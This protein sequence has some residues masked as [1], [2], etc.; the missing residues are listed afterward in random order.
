MTYP[1]AE[2]KVACAATS[3]GARGPPEPSAT[4]V[5]SQAGTRE[6]C[7]ITGSPR[8]DRRQQSFEFEDQGRT[9][10]CS[11]EPSHPSRSDSWWYFGVTGDRT[12]YAV[13]Q[14]SSEDTR[15]SVQRRI[16]AHYSALL[17]R[18]AQIVPYRP[19]RKS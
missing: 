18:R 3:L 11:V 8:E 6:R 7:L 19:F 15:T 4:R 10:T 9:Y 13:F 14:A 12:R 17:E 1:I 5:E 2:P 16:V